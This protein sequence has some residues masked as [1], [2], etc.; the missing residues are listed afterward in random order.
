MTATGS[1]RAATGGLAWGSDKPGE[2]PSDPQP[3]GY[4]TRMPAKFPAACAETVQN[5]QNR[6]NCWLGMGALKSL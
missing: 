5:L 2:S 1:N 6:P 3:N 4:L